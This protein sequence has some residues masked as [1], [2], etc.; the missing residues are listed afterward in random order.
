ML[1]V[2]LFLTYKI[3]DLSL[4]QLRHN[5]HTQSVCRDKI[6]KFKVAAFVN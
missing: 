5:S 3:T 4:T 1:P 2:T 6:V